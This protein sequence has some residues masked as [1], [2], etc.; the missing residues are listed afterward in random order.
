MEKLYKVTFL[1]YTNYTRDTVY[2][3]D[4][5][6][7]SH[8]ADAKDLIIK[9]SDIK[10]WTKFGKGLEKL[11]FVGNLRIVNERTSDKE[12]LYRIDFVEDSTF[13]EENEDMIVQESDLDEWKQYRSGI[14]TLEFV[15]F[16]GS[17]KS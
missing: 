4:E 5:S 8:Y 3:C 13:Y 17:L 1:E 6:N 16:L 2:Y 7:R 14:K 9:E 15:G 12:K 11:D 10:Y